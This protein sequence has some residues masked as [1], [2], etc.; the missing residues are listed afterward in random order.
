MKGTDDR[1]GG[2]E[3]A[4]YAAS[5]RAKLQLPVQSGGEGMALKTYILFFLLL[6]SNH[7]SNNVV[8][9]YNNNSRDNSTRTVMR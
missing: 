6:R 9:F 5:L 7:N 1:E 3:G 2:Y 8:I 4:G